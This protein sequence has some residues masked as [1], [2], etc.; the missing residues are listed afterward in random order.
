MKV[1]FAPVR[2]RSIG[3]NIQGKRKQYGLTHRVTSTIHAAMGD[4][5]TRVNIQVLLNDSTF[6]LWDKAQVIVAFSRTKKG[7]HLIFVDNKNETI[8]VLVD[9]IKRKTLWTDYM[10]HVVDL[11]TMNTDDDNSARIMT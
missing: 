1:G 10:E 3:R 8:L 9:I 4:T 7:K 5:L 11:V 6:K 2:T